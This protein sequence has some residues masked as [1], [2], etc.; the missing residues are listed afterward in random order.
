MKKLWVFDI[1]NTLAN[2]YHRWHHLQNGKKEWKEFFE[3]QHKDEPHQA[4]LDVLH[5][6]HSVGDKIIVVTGRDER[7]RDE[8][9]EWLN[10]HIHYEF[11]NE[12]LYMRP[13]G[14]REDDDILKVHIIKDWLNKNPGY[15]V[16]GIFEDRHRI[17]DAFRA[18]GWYTFEANQDR[19]EY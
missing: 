16:S 4:V 11:A 1:D 9:L 5:A 18:E 14:N 8:S 17:I 10:K 3:K 19:L 2:V 12:D 15:K 7:F 13:G 6:L